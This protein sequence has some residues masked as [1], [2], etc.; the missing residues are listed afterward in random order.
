[1][2][3]RSLLAS[4]LSAGLLTLSACSGDE[5]RGKLEIVEGFAGLIAGDEPR[6][7]V[8]GRDIL[9]GGGTAVDA[10]V[11]MAFTMS[12]TY[13]SRAGLG[14]G[15]ACI[16]F[17]SNS[18][19]RD[20][21]PVAEAYSFAPGG[22]SGALIPMLPRAMG[23]LHARHGV[24]R[25][26][27]LVSP[28]E[29]L[30]RFGH[31]VSRAFAKDIRDAAGIVVAD[32]ELATSL[33]NRAG[34]LA[35]EGDVVVQN[36]L[37]GL[38]SAIRQQGAGYLYGGPYARRLTEAAAEVG[39]EITLQG[40]AD[41]LPTVGP[42][43]RM[44][45]GGDTIYLAPPPATG[46]V[47][48]GQIYGALSEVE[49]YVDEAAAGQAHLMAETSMR[50]FAGQAVWMNSSGGV[51]RGL[52]PLLEEDALEDLL[53]D[54]DEARHK[55]AA[56]FAPVP[57]EITS[58]P[59]AAG[60]VAAD[61]WGS[62]VACSFTMNGLFG[63]GRML[64]GSGLL[65]ADEQTPGAV[66]LAPVVIGN[67]A[68]G[69]LRFAGVVSGGLASPSALATVMLLA[70]ED[71]KPLA[72][73]IGAP[74]AAHVGLPDITWVEPGLSAAAGSLEGRGHKVVEAPSVG[75]VS[76]LVCLNGILN[77]EATCE[78]VSDPRGNGLALRVQ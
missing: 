59:Y 72:E 64:P 28:A 61:R 33:S 50:A 7:V 42:P 14:G 78:V 13:P 29:R 77:S 75:S 41:A 68:T 65:L 70:L 74:R 3:S 53:A 69:D 39:I 55:A 10:A 2:M 4:F 52:Q 34:T 57:R 67:E 49:D 45:F 76:A 11:A 20:L 35:S 24:M 47:L 40:L 6:A 73:A 51:D 58:N 17:S 18:F 23:V 30:A 31:P 25:W 66:A 22:G 71:E 44:G 54:Y 12:V 8:I 37:S 19:D 1:M 16:V 48:V 27:S 21:K 15:G 56:S 5:D 9:G 43:L 26:S 46:G 63:S 60:F 32:E 62:S 38:L 36:A